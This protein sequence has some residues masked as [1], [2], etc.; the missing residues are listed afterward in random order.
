[1]GFVQEKCFYSRDCQTKHA[2]V[3]DQDEAKQHL[4]D[5]RGHCLILFLDKSPRH[6]YVG[7][8]F[9]VYFHDLFEQRACFF[10]IRGGIVLQILDGKGSCARKEKTRVRA[11]KQLET[12]NAFGIPNGSQ[13][14]LAETKV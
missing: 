4:R 8:H 9:I 12:I 14:Q 6:I 11:T 2:A 3:K 5:K 7:L 1:M 10:K 13:Q